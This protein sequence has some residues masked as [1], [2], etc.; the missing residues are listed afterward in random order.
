MAQTFKGTAVSFIINGNDLATQPLFAF[1]NGLLSRATVIIKRLVIQNDP[2]NVQTVV[3]P[4]TKTSRAVGSVTGGI[5]LAK[6]PFD[7]T[8][9]SDPYVVIRAAI[10]SGSPIIATSGNTNWLQNPGRMHTLFAKVQG[11]DL[12][13]LPMIVGRS[14]SPFVLYP[15]QILLVELKAAGATSNPSIANNFFVQCVWEEETYGTFNISG[16][17]KLSGDPISGAKVAVIEASDE[18]MSNARLVEVVTTDALGQWSSKIGYGHVGAAL[19]QYTLDGLY[20][21]TSSQ[22]FLEQ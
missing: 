6:C 14:D 17:V 1:E 2:V 11:M 20:Y 8:E 18:N 9:T 13:Q 4:Q 5:T 3:M 10:A 12:N 19:V 16:T 22:P 21:T 7:T 15:G